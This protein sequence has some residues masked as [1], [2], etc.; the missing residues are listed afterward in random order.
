MLTKCILAL[1]IV[2]RA[3]TC[4]AETCSVGTGSTIN[5]MHISWT[6]RWVPSAVFNYVTFT[7]WC[8]TLSSVWYKITRAI[9]A[10]ASTALRT[11]CQLAGIRIAARVCTFS[12]TSTVTNLIPFSYSISTNRITHSHSGLVKEAHVQVLSIAF[13]EVAY[14]AVTPL[15]WWREAR[16]SGHDASSCITVS[17]ITHLTIRSRF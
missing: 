8:S 13:I 5:S 7:T 9:A 3:W 11:S 4:I 14:T 10:W 16:H 1:C 2:C 17:T 12:R 6:I 15:S